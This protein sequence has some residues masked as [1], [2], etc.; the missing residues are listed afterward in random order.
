MP[1]AQKTSDLSDAVIK[2]IA[3]FANY[4]GTVDTKTV[5]SCFRSAAAQHGVTPA[6]LPVNLWHI[7]N[8]FN[9]FMPDARHSLQDLTRR[10]HAA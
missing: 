6:Q 1:S 3:D 4:D 8:N 2:E 5:L 7:F 9:G 10:I